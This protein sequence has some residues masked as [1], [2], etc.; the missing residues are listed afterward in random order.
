ML[1]VI[2]EFT[3]ECTAVRVERNLK[4]VD[5]ADVL[6]D[7]FILRGILGHIRSNSVQYSEYVAVLAADHYRFDFGRGD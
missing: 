7:L 4:A 5:V 6:T 2:D 1:N 3:G